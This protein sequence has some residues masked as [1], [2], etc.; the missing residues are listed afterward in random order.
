MN[1][2]IKKRFDL[3]VEAANET[4]TK[5]F[6]LDKSIVLVKGILVSAD[7]DD[8]L[9]YPGSQKIEINKQDY[10]PDGYESKLLMSGINVPPR[11]R[12][13]DLGDVNSGNGAIK[14]TYKDNED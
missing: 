8:L 3:S 9:Y 12:F 13:F 14:V 10:F 1:Q 2:P 4:I 6:E 7:K 11:Q 5:T